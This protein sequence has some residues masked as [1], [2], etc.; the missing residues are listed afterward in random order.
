M[1]KRYQWTSAAPEPR[2]GERPKRVKT[3]AEAHHDTMV[4]E[5]PNQG[6]IA[7]TRQRRTPREGISL[8]SAVG[9]QAT[10]PKTVAPKLNKGST[11][12]TSTLNTKRNTKATKSP[13]TV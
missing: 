5:D 12:W 10:T 9:N 8:V 13:S 1:T 4:T 2:Y 6:T 7:A 3:K 11:L